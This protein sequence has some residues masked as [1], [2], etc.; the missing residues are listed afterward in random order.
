MHQ[1]LFLDTNICIEWMFNRSSEISNFITSKIQLHCVHISKYVLAEFIRTIVKDA[2]N[3]HSILEDEND[4]DRVQ[5]KLYSIL[6]SEDDHQNRVVS[7]YILL[8]ESIDYPM[9][10]PDINFAKRAI[11]N[12]AQCSIKI[13]KKQFNILDS[14]I[15]CELASSKPKSVG[16]KFK[17]EFPCESGIN[18]TDCSIVHYITS[19]IMFLNQIEAGLIAES[20]PYFT[21]LRDLIIQFNSC[22]LLDCSLKYC[23]ILGDVIVLDDCPSDYLLLSKDHHFRTLCSITGH[24]L[25]MMD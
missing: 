23:K 5:R 22:S 8:M 6:E 12:Y 18:R 9:G 21:M 7:R 4:L 19:N 15:D 3:L 11:K 24:N 14:N 10:R 25:R 13:L 1:N 16:S 20:E 2:C 17:I